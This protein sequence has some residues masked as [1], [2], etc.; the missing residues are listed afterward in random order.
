[1]KCLS[2]IN[3]RVMVLKICNVYSLDKLKQKG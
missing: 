2:I 3:V 1:M